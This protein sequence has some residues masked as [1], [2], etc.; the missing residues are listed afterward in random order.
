MALK[1]D[2][3]MILKHTQSKKKGRRPRRGKLSVGE[4]DGKAP[5]LLDAVVWRCA[6]A[7]KVEGDMVLKRTEREKGRCPRRGVFKCNTAGTCCFVFR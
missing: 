6:M 2:G 5:H 4:V 3:N 1:V 7:V